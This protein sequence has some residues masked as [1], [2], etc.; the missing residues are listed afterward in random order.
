[1]E[2]APIPISKVIVNGVR[3]RTLAPISE[4]VVAELVMEPLAPVSEV[5]VTNQD[6]EPSTPNLGGKP[7]VKRLNC[8]LYFLNLF[9]LR[10][11]S[12]LRRASSPRRLGLCLS[13]QGRARFYY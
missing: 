8:W 3:N 11:I 2:S 9:L 10:W 6:M 12:R 1:M 4:D 7:L 13:F 5:V